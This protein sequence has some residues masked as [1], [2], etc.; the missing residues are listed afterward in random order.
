MSK[1]QKE[2]LMKKRE[3]QKSQIFKDNNFEFKPNLSY[4]E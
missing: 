4:H 2:E 3:E 1:E